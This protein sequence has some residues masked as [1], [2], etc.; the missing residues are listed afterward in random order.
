MTERNNGGINGYPDS[1]PARIHS[2][3]LGEGTISFKPNG[4]EIIAGSYQDLMNAGITIMPEAAARHFGEEGMQQYRDW[5][6]NNA[7]EK[8]RQAIPTTLFER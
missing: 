4:Q 6:A 1:N 5:I 2:E 7:R 8:S 3:Q